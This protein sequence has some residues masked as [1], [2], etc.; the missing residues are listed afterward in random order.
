[1]T[2]YAKNSD[3]L[4]LVDFKSM[5]RKKILIIYLLYQRLCF[6]IDLLLIF[7]LCARAG[8]RPG[9]CFGLAEK[10]YSY[11]SMWVHLEDKTGHWKYFPS[12]PYSRVRIP[13]HPLE[14]RLSEVGPRLL[15]LLCIRRKFQVPH[16][17][18][19]C[20]PGPACPSLSAHPGLPAFLRDRAANTWRSLCSHVLLVCRWWL[21]HGDHL[22]KGFILNFL[23]LWVEVSVTKYSIHFSCCSVNCGRGGRGGHRGHGYHLYTPPPEEV[24]EFGH[25]VFFSEK[26]QGIPFIKPKVVYKQCAIQPEAGWRV[27]KPSAW[28]K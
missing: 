26:A 14:A 8:A 17:V 16:S 4:I 21:L 6:I 11:S 7:P 13:V 25:P 22:W 23:L 3:E 18:A 2:S 28:N 27:H 9:H 24:L 19:F 1:M 5:I 10:H 12:F 15:C 20:L